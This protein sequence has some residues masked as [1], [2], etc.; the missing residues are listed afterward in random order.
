MGSYRF[1]N[2]AMLTS[3]SHSEVRSEDSKS[4]SK[5]IEDVSSQSMQPKFKK[6]RRNKTRISFVPRIKAKLD[7]Y[8][9]ACHQKALV[10]MRQLQFV[11]KALLNGHIYPLE[12]E[13]YK[14][15]S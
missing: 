15:L 3:S 12:A 5:M 8:L 14:H 4:V 7:S 13:L 2:E 1:L 6:A 11:E 9:D 10:L